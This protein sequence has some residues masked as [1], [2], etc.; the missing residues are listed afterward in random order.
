MVIPLLQVIMFGMGA[1]ISWD[2]ITQIA[3]APYPILVGLVCQF[4]IMP[5]VGAVLAYTLPLPLDV[6]AGLILVGCAPS[7]VASSVM[8]YLAGANLALSVA[9]T[10]SATL[11]APLLTPAL[12]KL[13]AGRIVTI[14]VM[15]M[16]WDITK[17]V[18][19]PVIG[20][21][22]VNRLLF[23]RLRMFLRALPLLSMTCIAM[24]TVIITA[25]AHRNLTTV[26]GTLIAA[27]LVHNLLGYLFGYCGA[28]L[29][30]LPQ[31]DCRTVAIEV[32]LQNSGLA[33]GI[34][35]KLGQVA[36]LGLAAVVF[37][38]LMSITGSALAM[39]WRRRTPQ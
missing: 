23:L 15:A 35:T 5:I 4:T 34:A 39:W 29:M 12:M 11:L 6:A 9:I 30:R 14:D 32:G 1:Q 31:R 21:L 25:T 2:E 20:G 28:R 33:L 22:L 26:G 13:L 19:L 18:A 3:R 10:V 7:G 17:M 36:T 16:M 37:G 24:L 27:T 8:V 38:P